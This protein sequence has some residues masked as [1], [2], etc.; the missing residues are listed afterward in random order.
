MELPPKNTKAATPPKNLFRTVY[1][2][3][4]ILIHRMLFYNAFALVA[5]FIIKYILYLC[6]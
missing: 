1:H 2:L 5:Q 4:L 3:L 6:P